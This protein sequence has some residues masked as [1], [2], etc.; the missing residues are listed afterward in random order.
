MRE[1]ESP[2]RLRIVVTDEETGEHVIVATGIETMALVV[3][4]DTP[5]SEEYRRVVLGDLEL[6]QSLLLDTLE[7]V[8]QWSGSGAEIDLDDLFQELLEEALEDLPLH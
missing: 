5:H 2:R 7:D 3:A 1:H 8:L 4:P 6:V